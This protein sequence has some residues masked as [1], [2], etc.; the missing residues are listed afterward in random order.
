MWAFPAPNTVR[1][2]ATLNTVTVII[3]G[4]EEVLQFGVNESYTLYI[5]SS[6][7]VITAPN[8]WG[9]MYGL[10]TFFQLVQLNP[11]ESSSSTGGGGVGGGGVVASEGGADTLA[12]GEGPSFS[13]GLAEGVPL[14]I[15]DAPFVGWRGLM[16]DTARHFLSVPLIKRTVDAMAAAKMNDLHWHITDD[17]SFPVCLESH[18]ELCKAAAY[19]SR[20]TGAM[21]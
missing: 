12:D 21:M 16:I 8:Q 2:G 5:N 4:E 3:Q 18:P 19:R 11:V 10:E 9:A 14:T 1:V 15:Q 20:A 7:A 13:Y 17:Q 6:N